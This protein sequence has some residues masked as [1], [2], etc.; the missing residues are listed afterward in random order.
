MVQQT[1]PNILVS[2]GYDYI[3]EYENEVF[4]YK[5]GW[6]SVCAQSND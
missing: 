5:L 6:P 1:V 2:L 4:F 3:D